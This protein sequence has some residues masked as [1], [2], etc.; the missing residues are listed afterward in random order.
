MGF[1]YCFISFGLV[2]SMLLMIMVCLLRDKAKAA[3]EK[4]KK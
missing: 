2:Q 1:F 3:L 4:K